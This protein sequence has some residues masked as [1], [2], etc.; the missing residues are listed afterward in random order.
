M[1]RPVL[2][3]ILCLL[4]GLLAWWELRHLGG[5]EEQI[6]EVRQTA[7]LSHVSETKEETP[8][9]VMPMESTQT[10]V[11]ISPNANPPPAAAGDDKTG[12]R[13]KR[14]YMLSLDKGALTFL[15]QQDI[16]GDFAPKRR[17]PEEWSGML[18]CRLLSE[19]NAVLAEELLPAPDH[20]CAVLDPKSGSDKPVQYTVP[21]PVVFQVRLPRVK[22]A[23]RLDIIRIIQ[24]GEPPLE[25]LL[26]SIPLPK[27]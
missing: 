15:E 20:L 24:P 3:L 18:R 13:F 5:A 16:E 8:G 26:G 22:G 14:A 4:A 9:K 10:T 21:G 11:N 17:K 12:P 7:P 6:A 1:R 19:S 25:G 2:V 23:T 27:S